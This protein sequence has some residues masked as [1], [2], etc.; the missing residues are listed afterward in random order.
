MSEASA[1]RWSVERAAA[2]ADDVGWLVGCNY[3][4]RT[5][6]NQLEMWQAETFDPSTIEQELRW[7]A[8]LGFNCH[9]VYLHDLLWEDASAFF[10]RVDRFLGLCE[11]TGHRVI[12][13]LL[14]DCWSHESA[15]G[16]QP[17][18]LPGVHNARWLQSPA[19]S[20]K[21]RWSEPDRARMRAYVRGVVERFGRDPRV[22]LWDLYNEP[23]NRN[24]GDARPPADTEFDSAPILR[25][26][27][28]WARAAE[29]MQPLTAGCWR[30]DPLFA[31]L[32]AE[33]RRLSDVLTFHHYGRVE[34]LPA[35]ID[36]VRGD[37]PA[38][39]PMVCTEYMARTTGNTFASHLPEL[40]RR[41]I[42]AIHWGLV[43]GRSQ[44]KFPWG[45]PEGAPEPDPWH[46]EVLHPDGS[47]YRPEEAALI[48]EVTGHGE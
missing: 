5:A 18:P 31:E 16:P 21:C 1:G 7:S 28:G 13:T 35:V 37:E 10:A 6:S 45:S 42:G 2:W 12:L 14:D 9:R 48:R 36:T 19:Y 17:E 23:G 33:Q 47:P 4:P 27:F 3:N 39:R 40:K 41:G 30:F 32:N 25:D 8:D 26:V 24:T 38:E 46:H 29:P 22:V 43:D 20:V 15:L 34:K 44:T 11:R